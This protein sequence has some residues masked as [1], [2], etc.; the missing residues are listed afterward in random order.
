[1]TKD[2]YKVCNVSPF[3]IILDFK[4]VNSQECALIIIAL[5]M[6]YRRYYSVFMYSFILKHLT[7]YGYKFRDDLLTLSQYVYTK[8]R[9][10]I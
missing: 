5:D 6:L 7:V 1:M 8:H 2:H 4:F 9:R 3:G 10:Y